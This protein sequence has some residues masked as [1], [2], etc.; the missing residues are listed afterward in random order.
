MREIDTTPCVVKAACAAREHKYVGVIDGGSANLD[1]I[2]GRK[3]QGMKH[4][5]KKET[6]WKK[7]QITGARRPFHRFYF[8]LPSLLDCP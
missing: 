8:L 5:G 2:S 1:E 3:K 7:M 4:S 6:V